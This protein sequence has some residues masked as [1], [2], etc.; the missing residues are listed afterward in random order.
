VRLFGECELAG[1]T[2]GR[3]AR[4]AGG[5]ELWGRGDG[6]EGGGGAAL[7]R[8][9]DEECAEIGVREARNWSK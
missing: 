7:E 1:V 5:V 3:S 4:L 9:E 2:T 6:G 8:L